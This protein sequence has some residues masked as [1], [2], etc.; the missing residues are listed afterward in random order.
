MTGTIHKNK[1][2]MIAFFNFSKIAF[3]SL[4]NMKISFLKNKFGEKGKKNILNIQFEKK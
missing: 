1:A 3:Y 2:A 4:F